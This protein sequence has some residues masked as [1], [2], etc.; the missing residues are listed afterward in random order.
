MA[1][2]PTQP[3]L[4]DLPEKDIQPF[5][6]AGL[7]AGGYLLICSAYI[8]I[9][10][11]IVADIAGSIETMQRL[12]LIKGIVFVL[13]TALLIF[14]VMWP[15]LRRIRSASEEIHQYQQNLQRTERAAATGMVAMTTAHDMNTHLQQLIMLQHELRTTQPSREITDLLDLQESE[16]QKLSD[17]AE[18]LMRS[19]EQTSL[20]TIRAI[21]LKPFIHRLKVH[22]NWLPEVQSATISTEFR[23]APVLEGKPMLLQQAL[24]NLLQNAGEATKGTGRIQ[25]RAEATDDGVCIEVHD[26]GP[27]IPAAQQDQVLQPFHTTKDHGSGLGLLTVSRCAQ[28]HSGMVEITDSPLGGACFRLKLRSQSP[29]N[30][31]A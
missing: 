7:L 29:Y 28:E 15:L 26:N 21:D 31:S 23:D 22:A 24:L 19:H 27:G 17:L 14:F 10:D 6:T 13:M 20:D 30:Q 12:E 9:S 4:N 16:I 18:R 25:I 1:A 11:R 2:R 5:R 8:W 3:Q